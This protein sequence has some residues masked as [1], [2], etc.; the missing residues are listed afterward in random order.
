MTGSPRTAKFS[1]RAPTSMKSTSGSI[2][3]F[4]IDV[5]LQNRASRSG[6]Y[7]GKAC[8]EFCVASGCQCRSRPCMPL[9]KRWSTCQYI[10][11]VT[12][13]TNNLSC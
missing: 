13:E 12:D 10:E 11:K 4:A 1:F 2:S 8:R 9:Q 6:A 7:A 3:I 5:S